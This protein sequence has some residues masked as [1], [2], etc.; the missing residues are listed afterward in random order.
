MPDLLRRAARPARPNTLVAAARGYSAAQ[1]NSGNL[2]VFRDEGWQKEAWHFWRTL[3]EVWNGLD[4]RSRAI[5]RVRLTAAEMVPGGDEPEVL[6]T[7]PAAELMESFYGGVAGQSAFLRGISTHLDVPGEGW[8]VAE[9]AAAAIPLEQADWSVQSTESFRTSGSGDAATFRL[10]VSDSAWRPLLPD[11]MPVRIWEPDAQFPWR[12]F[13]TMQPA[14]PIC[15]RIDL[16]DRQLTARLLSRLALNGIL[17]IPQE[18]TIAVPEEFQDAPDPF[19]AMLIEIASRNIANPGSAS[20]ALPIP[21]TFQSDLIEKWRLLTFAD[22]MDEHLLAE[23]DGELDRLATTLNLSKE[24]LTGMGDV[25]HWGISQLEE[26][27][28]N[29]S[30]VPTVETICGGVLKGYLQPL[31]SEAGESLVGPRGGKIVCWYDTSELTSTPDKSKVTIELYDRGEA[32]GAAARREAGLDEADAMTDDE[33]ADWGRKRLVQSATE[34]APAIV[35]EWGGDEIPGVG[36]SGPAGNPAA[37]PPAPS[38][39]TPGAP[40]PTR[41]DEEPTDAAPPVRQA[42]TLQRLVRASAALANGQAAARQDVA[43]LKDLVVAGQARQDQANGHRN[44]KYEPQ[45]RRR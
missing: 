10:R 3:G 33:L 38:A 14:L 27:E 11:A 45:H 24:R 30:I 36:V 16:L 23:R 1:I 7:G 15:R 35:A 32:S 20:A 22:D 21:I 42:A 5:S 43:A 6:D 37:P 29:T 34:A 2:D 41:G 26:G 40:P 9:R 8:L 39:P 18:G 4:W 25:N 19:V 12:A 13:S 44:G 17:L 31:L 28:V